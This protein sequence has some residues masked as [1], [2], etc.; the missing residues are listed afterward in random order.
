MDNY[1]K[2][3]NTIRAIIIIMLGI[4]IFV[5]FRFDFGMIG[6]VMNIMTLLIMSL[7]IRY[8]DRSGL[9]KVNEFSRDIDNLMTEADRTAEEYKDQRD[10]MET[11]VLELDSFLMCDEV[12]ERYRAYVNAYRKE[13]EIDCNIADYLNY[14]QLTEKL[15]LRF[16]EILP[17]ILTALGILG[18]FIGLAF[19]LTGFD[20]SSA[21]TM[22]ESIQT[23]VSGINVAF[24]TSIYGIVLS[25]YLNSFSNSVLERF[26]EKLV[27][28]ENRFDAFGMNRSEQSIWMRLYNEEKR[29]TS[30]LD[31][32][33]TEFP[34][35][36]SDTLGKNLSKSFNLTNSNIQNLMGQIQ[37]RENQAME[38]LVQNFLKQLTQGIK[39][40]YDSMAAT[41]DDLS[42]SF[43]E[44]NQSVTT[45]SEWQK[46]MTEEI[47][48]FVSEVSESNRRMEAINRENAEQMKQFHLVLQNFSDTM[49]NITG[50][51]EACYQ[52]EEH[53]YDKMQHV[54]E[55]QDAIADKLERVVQV[56]ED[57]GQNLKNRSR[58]LEKRNDDLGEIGTE[59]KNYQQECREQLS[60]MMDIY[61]EVQKAQEIRKE[62]A[63][64]LQGMQLELETLEWKVNHLVDRMGD[65]SLKSDSQKMAREMTMIRQNLQEEIAQMRDNLLSAIEDTTLK[66]KFKKV[67]HK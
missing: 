1:M 41:V 30:S 8:A 20:Y 45:L 54:V 50:S 12:K 19:G 62:D 58:E 52:K 3:I 48:K 13:E 16:C 11:M 57:S 40:N 34:K 27:V 7:M 47:Q 63:S 46:G 42:E 26:E 60:Q 67:F 5:T 66:G 44:L 28:L 56:Y 64:Q 55:Q 36:L 31:Q 14:D 59:L 32:L 29:Q 17:S 6:L 4:T 37:E 65:L 39:S 53:L 35:H 51:L 2:K 9:R 43:Q 49:E 21:D 10:V 25:I 24:Y 22:R 18:T 23:F 33:N 61:K 38:T 15:P